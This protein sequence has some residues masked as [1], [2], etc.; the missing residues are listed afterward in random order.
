MRT[1]KHRVL[2]RG[3]SQVPGDE[4]PPQSGQKTMVLVLV[5]GNLS[6]SAGTLR[7]QSQTNEGYDTAYQTIYD[8][9]PHCRNCGC[10]LRGCRCVRHNGNAQLQVRWMGLANYRERPVFQ[11]LD[12]K[13]AVVGADT[14]IHPAQPCALYLSGRSVRDDP[15]RRSTKSHRSI[16]NRVFWP[17]W[18]HDLVD[19]DR[20]VTLNVNFS[21]H[22]MTIAC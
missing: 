3:L 13:I 15:L 14:H 20:R 11:S 9:L 7:A 4:S 16:L 22:G 2:R 18:Q 5:R 19:G 10:L 1:T 8:A 6:M 17:R 21:S 12:C